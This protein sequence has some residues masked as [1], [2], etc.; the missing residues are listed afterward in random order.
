LVFI[1]F[2]DLNKSE[3]ISTEILVHS[4]ITC[5]IDYG[6]VMLYGLPEVS[7]RKLQRLQNA[8]ARLVALKS[9]RD[10][11]S[12][13]LKDLHWL[14][15]KFRIKFKICLLVYK[16]LNG[17]GPEYLRDLLT[18]PS[19]PRTLRSS[20]D[21][22]LLQVPRMRTETFGKRA[23]KYAGPDLWNKLPYDIRNCDTLT[24]FK[25]RLKTFY[26]YEAFN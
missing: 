4:F 25:K 2:T 24:V 17:C 13:I 22:L 11:I 8:A 7:V 9:K 19:R 20:S 14:P 3:S 5:H 26:F 1:N 18:F 23:F 15:V 12:E 10:S 6:N 16:C 21:N